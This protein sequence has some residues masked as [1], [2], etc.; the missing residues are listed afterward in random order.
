MTRTGCHEV[1][2][3]K[4]QVFA[5]IYNH[6]LSRRSFAT[7]AGDTVIK[8]NTLDYHQPDCGHPQSRTFNRTLTNLFK[9][10][11]YE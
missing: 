6:K 4:S 8:A 10:L 1:S 11:I 5:P 9:G 2:K 7:L 3:T